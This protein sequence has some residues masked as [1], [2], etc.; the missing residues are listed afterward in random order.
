MIKNTHKSQRDIGYMPVFCEGQQIASPA[1]KKQASAYINKLNSLAKE[2]KLRVNAT[3]NGVKHYD[4]LIEET[5][6]PKFGNKLILNIELTGIN[7][8]DIKG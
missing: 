3:V 2:G 7:L 4:V 5:D 8:A 6:L 1:N